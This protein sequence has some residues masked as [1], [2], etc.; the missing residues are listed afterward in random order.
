MAKSVLSE[1]HFRDEAAAVAFVEARLWPMGATCPKCGERTRVGRLNGKSTK[2]GTWKCYV[3]RKPFAVTIGTVMESSHIP[4]H[5]WLQGMHLICSSKKGFSANQLHRILGI[6]L[7]SAWFLGH[8]IR[9]AMK[10]LSWPDAGSL[11]GEGMTVEAD[12]T[13]I[14]GKA[15]NRAYGPIP[16]KHAVAALVE[17]GGRLRMFHVLNVT[18]SNLAPIIARHAH[19]DSA[20][21]SDE[22]NVYSHAGTWFK[23]HQTVNHSA[24]EYV[25]DDVYTNTIEG[26][27]SI[28][29]RGIYGVYQ[30]VSEAHLKRYLAEFDFRYSYRI[31]TGYDDT[32]RTDRAIRGLAGKRLTYRTTRGGR[33]TAIVPQARA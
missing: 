30:H 12:E 5:V 23:S 26:C 24:K 7:K 18:T 20:F 27:F 10:E 13:W 16:P 32:A 3:C 28:L 9:E 1:P 11:G 19:P 33:P 21:M 4:L 15:A 29:K 22:S 14:G 31:K 17:R 6:T 8:R 2:V 25:R